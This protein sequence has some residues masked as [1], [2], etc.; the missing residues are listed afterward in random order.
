MTYNNLKLIAHHNVL[1]WIIQL[2]FDSEDHLVSGSE[3]ATI[4]LWDLIS[5][6]VI[7]VIPQDTGI[8]CLVAS[9]LKGQED[10]VVLFGDRDGKMSY[11]DMQTLTVSLI[12]WQ[13][14]QLSK[15]VFWI[16]TTDGVSIDDIFDVI[17]II[18]FSIFHGIM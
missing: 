9:K 16:S 17:E 13:K 8:S 15:N 11:L 6:D 18:K 5:G 14:L 10:D 3:D 7:H 2:I 12:F 1:G 4:R